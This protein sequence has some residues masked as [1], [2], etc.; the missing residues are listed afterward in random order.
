MAASELPR[1]DRAALLLQRGV[2][3]LLAPLWIP[4]VILVMR[5]G[6]GWRIEGLPEARRRFQRLRSERSGGLLV[7]ANHLTMLDSFLIAWALAPPWWYVL[8]YA[9]V[10]WNTP[11]RENF[12][13]IWW[14]RALVYVMKCIPV[15]RGGDRREVGRVLSRIGWL[16]ARGEAAL[17]FPEGGRSRSGRVAT[18]AS[19]YGVGRVV[20]ALPSARVL[21]VYLR[22]DQQQSWSD[23][24]RR[25]ERFRVRI[26]E[27]EPKCES[28]GLRGSLEMSRQVLAKLAEMEREHFD[29][30]Q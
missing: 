29:G 2:G 4:L 11:E 14:M 20:R 28:G 5:V 6:M 27:L 8:H 26:E 23:V 1:G 13:R 25:N 17:I 10:P 3:R 19:T 24:P 7:C 30:R 15:Q 12:A 18:D 21:C 16:L 9:W 22:G